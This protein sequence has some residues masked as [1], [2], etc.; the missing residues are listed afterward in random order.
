MKITRVINNV[1]L[2]ERII[3]KEKMINRARYHNKFNKNFN[4]IY[5][6]WKKA[7]KNKY[8]PDHAELFDYA[9][10]CCIFLD[11]FLVLDVKNEL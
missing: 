11:K 7:T 10:K 1:K 6:M 4:R 3:M 8:M 5:R 9:T 2:Q